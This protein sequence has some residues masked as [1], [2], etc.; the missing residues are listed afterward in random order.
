[1][2]EK[3]VEPID[4]AKGQLIG[5]GRDVNGNKIAKFKTKLGKGFSIQTNGNLPLLHKVS[6]IGEIKDLAGV[7]KEVLAYIKDYGTKMQK[8]LLEMKIIGEANTKTGICPTCGSKYLLATN[9]CV[10]CKKKVKKETTK[11]DDKKSDKKKES[12]I[13]D[14]VNEVTIGNVILEKGDKIEVLKEEQFFF[15]QGLPA[16]KQESIREILK[17]LYLSE[18][19]IYSI[20]G[21]DTMYAIALEELYLSKYQLTKLVQ[22]KD[23][24][25]IFSYQKSYPEF[26]I[27]KE[28]I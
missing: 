25:A 8:G 28:M 11:K 24:E 17:V 3:K 23:F 15:I 2:N 16:S 18:K 20:V 10:K 26:W 6:D 4:I 22:I 14:I 13:I 1:M 5:L 19:N 7:K 9:Y 12:T 27:T 21:H